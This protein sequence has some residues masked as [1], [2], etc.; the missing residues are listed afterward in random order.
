MKI[1]S[2]G[3]LLDELSRDAGFIEERPASACLA[4]SREDVADAL[5]S[6]LA[7]GV[8]VTPR[9]SG[10]GIPTQSVGRGQVLLQSG[11]RRATVSGRAVACEP[12]LVKADLNELL[13]GSGLWMPVD[14]SSYRACSV[15]GMVANNSSGTRTLKYGSTVD[16]VLGMELVLPGEGA[17][18]LRPSRP[19]QAVAE[20]GVLGRIA[21]LVVE[22]RELIEAEAPRVT[23]NSS[24]YRLD[25]A[26]HDGLFDPARL[27]VGSEGTLGVVT[28]A[29]F[30]LAPKPESR[31]LLVL[32]TALEELDAVASAL[33]PF[34]PSALELVD[35]EIFRKANR[36]AHISPY[37]RRG[38]QYLVFC[39]LD[40]SEEEVAGRLEAAASVP[41]VAGMEPLVVEG[42]SEV[43]AAWDA[44]NETLTIAAEL[45][46]GQKKVA[47]GVEDVVVPPQRLGEMV[48]LMTGEF[49]SRG[50]QYISYGHAGDANLHMR[51]M[52]DLKSER[53]KRVLGDLMRT[54]FE[55]T[56]R[57]GGS[58]TGEHGDGRLR[59]PYVKEQY[60]RTYELM[61][62]VK[63]LCDPK[64]LMNPGVKVV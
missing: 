49:D 62:E 11:R 53:D 17:R 38:E 14:P 26:L 52:L 4:E 35:K 32:E 37:V 3:P 18:A 41:K 10:T 51:P 23:K 56:W 29:T 22:N 7:A 28:E 64:G 5:R 55:A 48:K 31:V 34:T 27:F 44:R 13:R 8:P 15:G 63:R 59:A 57:M 47:P 50:L 61:L 6:A 46:D 30:S 12:G 45:R 20:A 43:S 24:G 60:P 40:G 2:Q 58:I 33:R 21:S 25:K 36:E 39:E 9:G 54:V 16:Y 19:E 1:V 42:Q